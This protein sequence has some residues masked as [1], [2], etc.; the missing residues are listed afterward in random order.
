M[1]YRNGTSAWK[2]SIHFSML[3]FYTPWKQQKILQ[4]FRAYRNA[5]FGRNK[6]ICFQNA[7]RS[8]R[9]QMFF[10]KGILKNFVI[11]TGKHLCWSLFFNKVAGLLVFSCEYCEI[12]K[13][14]FFY[15]TPLAVTS[16]LWTLPAGKKLFFVGVR[17]CDFKTLTVHWNLLLLT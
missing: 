3:H 1:G 8:S 17:A 16:L 6:L 9:S 2:G 10:K 14:S 11:F 12:F 7:F 13:N 4:I 5:I 15:R